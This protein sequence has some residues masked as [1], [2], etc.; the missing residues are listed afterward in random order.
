M[1]KYQFHLVSSFLKVP[2]TSVY[3]LLSE[4]SKLWPQSLKR[5]CFG[6]TR[7]WPWWQK[8]KMLCPYDGQ[9]ANVCFPSYIFYYFTDILWETKSP[10]LHF[11]V[12]MHWMYSNL[13]WVL[14]VPS[15][16]L[17]PFFSSSV[18]IVLFHFSAT[19][20]R[21]SCGLLCVQMLSVC[22][23]F[24]FSSVHLFVP[25]WAILAILSQILLWRPNG[26]TS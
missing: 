26:V 22:T 21:A 11:N 16:F 24:L 15:F 6:D 14:F 25:Y 5:L 1:T 2:S 17:S 18:I 3:E 20:H 8:H 23:A 12:C 13:D 4:L 7:L 10:C 19:L 9:S